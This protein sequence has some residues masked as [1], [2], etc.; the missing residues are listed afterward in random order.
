LSQEVEE[1]MRRVMG[2]T[3]PVVPEDAGPDGSWAAQALAYLDRRRAAGAPGDC[4]LPELFAALRQHDPE[5]TVTG[6]HDRLRRLHDRQTLRLIPFAGSPTEMQEPEYALL[7][8]N[9]LL[10]YATK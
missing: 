7:D 1:A 10:Y 8:G 6:F 5:L 4:P 3:A 9:A 2:T